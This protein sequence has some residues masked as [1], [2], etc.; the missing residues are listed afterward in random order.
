VRHWP[1]GTPEPARQSRAAVRG[2]AT[3]G[4][5]S[6]ARLR[7]PHPCGPAVWS[8]RAGRGAPW[9][10][11]P[12]QRPPARQAWACA[13]AGAAPARARRAASAP[14]RAPAAG[15]PRAARPPRLRR[16]LRA[17]AP[18]SPGPSLWGT[19]VS[20]EPHRL[21]RATSPGSRRPPSSRPA[22]P[23]ALAAAAPSSCG[24]ELRRTTA[25]RGC[26]ADRAC[27]RRPPATVA[28]HQ[29]MEKRHSDSCS[30]RSA[31]QTRGGIAAKAPRAAPPAPAGCSASS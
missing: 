29:G 25:L 18:V 22:P 10:G 27:P 30:T 19:A 31:P 23:G 13:W 24:R 14:R 8:P 11:A 20:Q 5:T 4:A 6:H 26:A 12:P 21:R 7:S 1:R 16:R 2:V 9:H 3:A 28:T 15:A 17:S